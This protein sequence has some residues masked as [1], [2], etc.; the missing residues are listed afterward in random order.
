MARHQH[1]GDL[2]VRPG[3]GADAGLLAH[4]AEA[5]LG[6]CHQTCREPPAA[7]QRELGPVGISPGLR[8]LVRRHQLDMRAGRQTAQQRRAQ[9][10]VFDDPAHRRRA[11]VLVGGFAMVEMEE[12]R[13]WPAVMAGVGDAD[14]ENG[15]SLVGQLRPDAQR[16]EQALA[17]VGDGGG[18]SVKA[19]IRER[20]QGDAVDQD[21]VEAC[22]SS[23][24]RQ[25]AAAQAGAHDGEIEP[26]ALHAS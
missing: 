23:R 15:L 2:V 13:A 8:H 7:L 21:R 17:G 14:V 16:R 25:Q 5:A 4:G 6:R 3:A 24:Q 22:L 9:E 26:V 1:D 12:H 18:P 20:R 10:A 11:L 19:R